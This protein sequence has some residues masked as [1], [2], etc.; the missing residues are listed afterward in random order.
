MTIVSSYFLLCS[1]DK[2]LIFVNACLPNTGAVV[3][4]ENDLFEVDESA[5]YVSICIVLKTPIK[6]DI[7]FNLIVSNGSAIGE[8]S[9]LLWIVHIRC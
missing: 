8:N 4:L 9:F 1:L 6:R 5:S 3:S 2:T 7:E